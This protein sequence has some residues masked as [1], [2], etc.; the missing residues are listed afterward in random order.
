M[1]DSSPADLAV[2][3]RSLGRRLAEADHDGVTAADV[4]AATNA[5]NAAVAAAASV[6]GSPSNTE[7]VASAIH[8]RTPAQWTDADL[9]AIQAAA[10][11]AAK[12]IRALQNT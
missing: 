10:N 6:L 1:S 9:S 11:D 3:F 8:D 7:D 2:A 4:A 5:V 12:A